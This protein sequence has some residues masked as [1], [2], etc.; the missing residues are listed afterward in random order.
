MNDEEAYQ[1]GKRIA[2][3]LVRSGRAIRIGESGGSR[4]GAQVVVWAGVIVAIVLAAIVL[5]AWLFI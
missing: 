2:D 1:H 3:E 4:S 5:A